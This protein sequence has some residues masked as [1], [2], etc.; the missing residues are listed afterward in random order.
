[1]VSVAS[2]DEDLE[3]LSGVCRFL[4]RALITL[5]V[6]SGVAASIAVLVALRVLPGIQGPG[7]FVLLALVIGPLLAVVG[8]LARIAALLWGGPV[9][10]GILACSVPMPLVAPVALGYAI[11]VTRR[12]LAE[13]GVA[14]SHCFLFRMRT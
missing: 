3:R 4:S 6:T 5:M 11:V 1:V 12:R 7:L 8:G 10:A 9:A 2:E 13:A 14:A